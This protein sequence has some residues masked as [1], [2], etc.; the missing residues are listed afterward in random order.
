MKDHSPC[1]HQIETQ[2]ETAL[3]DDEGLESFGSAGLPEIRQLEEALG[4]VESGSYGIRQKCSEEI[5]AE[6]LKA[7]PS[8][9]LYPDTTIPLKG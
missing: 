1:R 7:V 4:R 6:R 8:A 3:E 2:I 5:S 9:H